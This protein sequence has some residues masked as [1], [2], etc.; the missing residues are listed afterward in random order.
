MVRP[1]QGLAKYMQPAGTAEDVLLEGRVFLKIIC[2]HDGRGF[3][4]GR[5][6]CLQWFSG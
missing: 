5:A 3:N 4:D 1:L 2:R 6:C